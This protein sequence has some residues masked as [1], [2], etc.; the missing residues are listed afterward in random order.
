MENKKP[1]G[2]IKCSNNVEIAFWINETIEKNTGKKI[3]M[4]KPSISKSWKDKDGKWEQ[5]GFNLSMNDLFRL[6]ATQ[7]E[8]KK[9]EDKFRE[10]RHY[11][12]EE[13]D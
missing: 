5:R 13:G 6:Y 8:V 11:E 2:K 9:W 4:L 10:E 1:Y 3:Q 7:Y 12:D